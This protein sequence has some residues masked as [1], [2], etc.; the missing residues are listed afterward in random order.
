MCR[1]SAI[2]EDGVVSGGGKSIKYG[3]LLK[4]HDFKLAIPVTG[5][6]TSMMGISVAGNPPMKPVASYKVVGQS[7][8]NSVIESKITTQEAWVTDIKLPGMLLRRTIHP[9]TLG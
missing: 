4:D 1:G 5:D 7:F 2:S 6:L 3:A 8:P 9:K